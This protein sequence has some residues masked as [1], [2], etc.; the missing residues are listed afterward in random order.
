MEIYAGWLASAATMIAAMMTAA[1]LGSRV[2]GWGFVVFTVGSAAWGVVGLMS[3][4]TSL[5]I[6]NAFLFA[7][8]LFGV[9]RWLGKQAAYDD[10]GAAASRRTRHAPVP[11]LFSASWMLGAAVTGRD[12]KTFATVVDTMMKSRSKTLA[13]VVT[14]EGGVGGV[15][16]TLR[17]VSPEHLTIEDD[18]VTCD[19]DH[20]DWLALPVIED[21]HWPAAAPDADDRATAEVAA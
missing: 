20:R 19:L 2:T 16:E 4:Q 14:T 13:Y 5:A 10:G 7:V 12:G 6:T 1:N 21:D 11:T 15:G 18:A 8:N 3:G 9:W 17:A